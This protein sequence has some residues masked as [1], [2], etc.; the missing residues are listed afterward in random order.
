MNSIGKNN[1]PY[2]PVLALTVIVLFAVGGFIFRDRIVPSFLLG[3][4]GLSIQSLYGSAEA[5][6]DGKSLGTTPVTIED[7]PAKKHM[8]SLSNDKNT[9]EVSLNFVPRT[10][11][12]IGR[13]LGISDLFSS[14]QNFWMEKNASDSVLS[15]I[16]EP[17]NATVFIDNSEVGK[18]PYSDSALS[19]GDYDLRISYQGYEVQNTRI[20]IAKNYKLNVA[21]DLFPLPVP[22]EV[23]E[24]EGSKGLYNVISDNVAVTSNT[25][26]WVTAIL[27][28]NETRGV[29]LSGMGFNKEKVFDYFIDYDGNIFNKEGTK[30]GDDLTSLGEVE[31]GA[32]LA[33]IS[34]P[35]GL[36]DKAREAY[37]KVS[38]SVVSAGKTVTI[39]E[40]GMGWLRVRSTPSLD[41]EEISKATVGETYN[42]LEE[43][44]GW[45]KIKIDDST[46]GWVSSDYVELSE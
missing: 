2:V 33:R 37:Q 16:S 32:Y 34:D 18:T 5:K 42:V 38:G 40:T 17:A 19:E 20:K 21:F 24:F 22:P 23:K 12:A 6:M 13:D 1:F 29:N 8:L 44:T 11:V 14:G 39:L 4:A 45:V 30:M 9:Y 3:E 25:Q 41:G 26:D 10:I 31:K 35:E 46:E 43:G 28:W 7:T 27:Y 15:V 36:T